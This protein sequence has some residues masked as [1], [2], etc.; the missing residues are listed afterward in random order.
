MK[1]MVL[2]PI[3]FLAWL[4]VVLAAATA[5]Q[6]LVD[7]SRLSGDLQQDA[8]RSIS[9]LIV[10]GFF[11][12]MVPAV[13]GAWFF[14]SFA[15]LR[16]GKA[17]GVRLT[18]LAVLVAGSLFAALFTMP[19]L[20][21]LKAQVSRLDFQVPEGPI[22]SDDSVFFVYGEDGSGKANLLWHDT[23]AGAVF[24]LAGDVSKD[25]LHGELLMPREGKTIRMDDVV[26]GRQELYADTGMTGDLARL[27]LDG[28]TSY[29]R[30]TAGSFVNSAALAAATAALLASLWFLIR[31]TNWPLANTMFT[32]AAVAL[33]GLIPVALGSPVAAG[34]VGLVPTGLRGLVLP[35]SYA[36]LALLFFG[37]VLLLPSRADRQGGGNA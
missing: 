9:L 34:I 2:V 13:V 19:P 26:G 32:L 3:R 25:T 29:R 35:A 33:I 28:L 10:Q 4:F 17:K 31:L 23:A 18:M 37:G 6:V 8:A 7:F 12:W 11:V 1:D 20:E 22:L 21:Q 36:V 15:I 27:F 16:T 30:G 5:V 14:T 24:R